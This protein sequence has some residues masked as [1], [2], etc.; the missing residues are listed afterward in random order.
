V[1]EACD[2]GHP[3]LRKISRRENAVRILIHARFSIT[4]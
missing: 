2:N 3:D 1:N 4:A